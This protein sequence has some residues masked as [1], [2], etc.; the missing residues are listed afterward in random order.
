MVMEYGQDL[1]QIADTINRK[2]ISDKRLRNEQMRQGITDPNS[3]AA[4]NQTQLQQAQQPS[5]FWGAGRKEMSGDVDPTLVS[6][7]GGSTAKLGG[8]DFY[9]GNFDPSKASWATQ[10]ADDVDLGMGKY[11]IMQNGQELGTGYKSLADT[12]KDYNLPNF[13]PKETQKYLQTALPKEA[14][15]FY[16][17]SDIGVSVVDPNWLTANNYRQTAA[18]GSIPGI[19]PSLVEG[20]V[21]SY[22][23]L[24]PGYTTNGDNFYQSLEE[25]K[26][27]QDSQAGSY[28][29][30][31]TVRDWETLGQ[32]LNY[33]QVTGD[34][35]TPHAIGGNQVSDPITGLNTLFGSKPILYD[36]KLLGYN[37]Q[38]DV[39]PIQDQWNQQWDDIHRDKGGMGGKVTTNHSWDVG[40][41]NMGRS[42]NDPNWWRTNTLNNT[43]GTFTVTP[44]MASS[45][46]GWLNK[47]QFVRNS[48]S[49]ESSR[50][51]GGVRD[52]MSA[53]GSIVDMFV[54]W[55]FNTAKYVGANTA[56]MIGGAS[57]GDTAENSLKNQL[58]GW[59]VSQ[60]L[61]EI[62]SGLGNSM[63]AS[64]DPIIAGYSPTYAGVIDQAAAGAASGAIQGSQTD[65]GA[66]EGAL[67]GLAGGGLGYLGG[68]LASGATYDLGDIVSKMSGGAASGA[69]DSLFSKNNPIEGSLYGAMSGGLHGFLNSTARDQNQLDVEKSKQNKQ[70]TKA[71]MGLAKTLLKLRKK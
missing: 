42:Y 6:A 33:G 56:D 34:F 1:A 8:Q 32:L 24:T 65:M 64:T 43:D 37:Q 19:D 58:P 61:S 2:K 69:I 16:N 35:R 48:G 57:F 5:E 51:L 15:S 17:P 59:L 38:G 28:T 45:S 13:A 55:T 31:N 10:D 18:V 3:F 46:P 49:S 50:T 29:V 60:G 7:L 67:R 41:L 54:P 21:P 36:G 39:K 11:K 4:I 62:F 30:G 63:G 40:G 47:D 27:I 66:G 71:A 9:Y 23:R 22:E 25:A 68:G 26:A 52:T 20:Y 53:I 14:Y 44:E 12:I 70:T